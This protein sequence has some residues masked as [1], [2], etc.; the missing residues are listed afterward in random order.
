MCVIT[1][2]LNRYDDALLDIKKFL[3]FNYP[4]KVLVRTFISSLYFDT[5]F[6]E[7]LFL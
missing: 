2:K 3:D 4:E 1:L 6:I 5:F 7:V